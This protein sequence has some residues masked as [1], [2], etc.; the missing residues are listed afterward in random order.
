MSDADRAADFACCDLLARYASGADWID[1]SMFADVFWDDAKIDFGSFQADKSTYVT[2]I[3]GYRTG[4]LR[5]WHH[6]G[7][8]RIRISGEKALM[9]ATCLAHLRP[10]SPASDDEIY[11][12]R[13]LFEVECR[14]GDWRI[15]TLTYLMSLSQSL[16]ARGLEPALRKAEGLDTG[17]PLYALRCG[18]D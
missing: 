13:Y 11:H 1:E 7:L 9:E 18:P 8:P 14:G 6:F 2:L 12:G 16:P 4:Y 3:M 10:A 15:L 5:R 17:H